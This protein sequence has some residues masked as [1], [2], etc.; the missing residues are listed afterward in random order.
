MLSRDLLLGSGPAEVDPAAS[1]VTVPRGFTSAKVDFLRSEAGE[2]VVVP[3]GT[4][5]EIGICAHGSACEG[6][7]TL[8]EQKRLA[9]TREHFGPYEVEGPLRYNDRSDFNQGH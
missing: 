2:V 5:E 8:R 4:V 3:S 1:Q 7:E 6:F 9:L